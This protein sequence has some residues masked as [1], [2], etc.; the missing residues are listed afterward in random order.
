[1]SSKLEELWQTAKEVT[2][3]SYPQVPEGSERFIAIT[4][5][6]Y[7]RLLT[8]AI[9]EW[10]RRQVKRMELL[11]A[12]GER[13]HA[14]LIYAPSRK[15]PTKWRFQRPSELRV[16]PLHLTAADLM[17][18][19]PPFPG[20]VPPGALY[21]P[22]RLTERE[23]E[24]I[25]QVIEQKGRHALQDLPKVAM[26]LFIAC[27]PAVA[28]TI[29]QASELIRV[30][31]VSAGEFIRDERLINAWHVLGLWGILTS[32]LPPPNYKWIRWLMTI[33]ASYPSL[34][35][36]IIETCREWIGEMHNK[37]MT[38][39]E[40]LGAEQYL[41]GDFGWWYVHECLESGK[42]CAILAP[43]VCI[44]DSY[45]AIAFKD[46]Y[47]L[48]YPRIVSDIGDYVL[49]LHAFYR[50]GA[51]VYLV[52]GAE[53]AKAFIEP[54]TLGCWRCLRA[55]DVILVATPTPVTARRYKAPTFHHSGMPNFHEDVRLFVQ[56]GKRQLKELR[57]KL[58]V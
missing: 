2:R 58:Y 33:R 49:P 53:A 44:S 17:H 23:L 30:G 55:E 16:R 37:P 35:H 1:M 26:A 27:P 15:D 22:A 46:K 19:L 56:V 7:R 14:G 36:S 34:A 10:L 57:A 38:L 54:H 47:F 9:A 4:F 51:L 8:P 3:R 24:L 50:F 25:T 39:S 5:G 21:N 13:V 18:S 42:A 48:P 40:L 31:R 6:V 29:E 32:Q 52:K 41:W 28:L 45:A 12:W 20:Q 43:S 11:K